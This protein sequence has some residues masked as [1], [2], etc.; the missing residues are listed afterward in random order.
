MHA[1][2]SKPCHAVAVPSQLCGHGSLTTLLGSPLLPAEIRPRRLPQGLWT[3]LEHAAKV[4]A[5]AGRAWGALFV[6]AFFFSAVSFG[7]RL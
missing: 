2:M 7:F 1:W 3:R 5:Y 4:R 6:G